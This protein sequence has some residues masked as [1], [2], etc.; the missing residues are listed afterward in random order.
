MEVIK[1]DL[2]KSNFGE[3]WMLT[4]SPNPP[5]PHPPIFSS[6]EQIS[7]VMVKIPALDR[8]MLSHSWK[9]KAVDKHCPRLLNLLV[10]SCRGL[11]VCS[12]QIWVEYKFNREGGLHLIQCFPN[13]AQ[14]SAMTSHK[15]IFSLRLVRVHVGISPLWTR[16][17]CGRFW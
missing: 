10:R 16:Y 4:W 2:K 13:R 9:N 11:R 12:G 17:Y 6:K 15:N 14:F 7:W 8:H 5:P 3:I 1:S